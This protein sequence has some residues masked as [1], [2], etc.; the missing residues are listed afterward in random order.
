MNLQIDYELHFK[1]TL[2]SITNVIQSKPG[3]ML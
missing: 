3:R 2:N 1:I